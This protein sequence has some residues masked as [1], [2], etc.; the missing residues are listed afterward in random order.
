MFIVCKVNSFPVCAREVTGLKKILT[1]LIASCL[2]LRFG[3]DLWLFVAEFLKP[4][5]LVL[6]G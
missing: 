1:F 3:S 6:N 5:Q 2:F 4:L